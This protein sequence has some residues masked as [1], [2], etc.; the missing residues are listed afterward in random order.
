MVEAWLPEATQK[1]KGSAPS[2]AVVVARLQPDLVPKAGTYQVAST[3]VASFAG[4]QARDETYVIRAMG[5]EREECLQGRN[6]FLGQ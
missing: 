4:H 3:L 5:L 1:Q 6:E 2:K